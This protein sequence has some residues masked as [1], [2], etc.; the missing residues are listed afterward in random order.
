M[1]I[2][3]RELIDFKERKFPE[4]VCFEPIGIIH[5]SFESLKGIPIQSK[6]STSPGEIEI[7]EKCKPGIK[8]LSGFSHIY[9]IYNFDMVKLPVPLQSK[10]FLDNEKRGVFAGEISNDRDTAS[11]MHS[12]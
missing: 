6:M 7:F 4:R 1:E 8:D 9:C 3:K 12:F 5:S 11:N 2:T 10:P